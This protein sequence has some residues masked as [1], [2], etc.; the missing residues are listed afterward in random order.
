MC[1]D[2]LQE[3]GMDS[4]R[5]SSSRVRDFG[6]LKNEYKIVVF[7]LFDTIYKM[8]GSPEYLLPEGK[9]FNKSSLYHCN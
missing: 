3:N 9:E 2:K 6:K 8:L 1:W 4:F 5:D 7:Q